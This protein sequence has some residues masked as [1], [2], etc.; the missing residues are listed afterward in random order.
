[1]RCRREPD[2][3]GNGM[4]ET[5]YGI[6]ET[7]K[8]IRTH[9]ELTELQKGNLRVQAVKNEPFRNV[10]TTRLPRKIRGVRCVALSS[11]GEQ[12]KKMAVLQTTYHGDPEAESEPQPGWVLVALCA[13]HTDEKPIARK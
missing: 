12:C 13:E 4:A 3:K 7:R 8:Y 11:Q 2:E 1:M 6:P 5:F 9:P 10:I